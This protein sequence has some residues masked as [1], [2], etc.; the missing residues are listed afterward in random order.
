MKHKEDENIKIKISSKNK[1]YKYLPLNHNEKKG[2]SLISKFTF[3]L[4]FSLIVIFWFIISL[5][6]GN[7]QQIKT[8]L[9]RKS[10]DNEQNEKNFYEK[11]RTILNKEEIL[12]NEIMNN[13]QLF[14]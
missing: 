7:Q 5:F 10:I 13:I 9:S 2:L 11:L 14:N 3:L 1:Q 4:L 8:V 12:E 6:I